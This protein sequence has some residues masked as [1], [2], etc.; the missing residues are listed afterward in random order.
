MTDACERNPGPFCKDELNFHQVM[1]P[2]DET[3]I[4]RKLQQRLDSGEFISPNR[5]PNPQDRSMVLLA[6]TI[7]D[8]YLKVPGPAFMVLS[9]EM[10]QY[11]SKADKATADITNQE[12]KLVGDAWSQ[13]S[14]DQRKNIQLQ[15]EIRQFTGN[16]RTPA[17]ELDAFLSDVTT[18]IAPLEAQ[19]QATYQKVWKELPIELKKEI[20]REFTPAKPQSA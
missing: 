6:Q 9:Q 12:A 16:T 8:P 1:N 14:P 2:P 3:E 18:K 5:F 10:A 17:P 13:L 19:R 11:C 15:A 7:N 4:D 20:L